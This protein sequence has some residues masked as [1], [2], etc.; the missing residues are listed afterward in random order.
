MDAGPDAI[1]RGTLLFEREVPVDDLRVGDV[2]TFD[3][4]VTGADRKVTHRVV[5]VRP[6]GL[7]TQGD[8]ATA[9]DPWVLDPPGATLPRVVARVPWAGYAYALPA[10]ALSW[11]L[12][13]VSALGLGATAVRG[14]RPV[15]TEP[16]PGVTIPIAQSG[17]QP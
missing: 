13:L 1:S 10:R 11:A 7:V 2:I 4:P 8:A 9:P 12:L 14:R 17:H 6:D 16:H 5:E 3:R 15:T